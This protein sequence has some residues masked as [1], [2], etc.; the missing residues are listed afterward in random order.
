LKTPEKNK[1]GDECGDAEKADYFRQGI[2]DKANDHGIAIDMNA[3]VAIR[4]FITYFVELSVSV[5]GER[6]IVFNPIDR[7]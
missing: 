6:L 5:R 7:R 3:G 4:V 2:I 1:K